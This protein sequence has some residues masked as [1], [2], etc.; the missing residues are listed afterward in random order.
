MENTHHRKF[1]LKTA[2]CVDLTNFGESFL[3]ICGGALLCGWPTV[4]AG[5]VREIDVFTMFRQ[6]ERTDNESVGRVSRGD[7]KA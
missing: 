3:E 6:A 2:G 1:G 7:R 4:R 5:R